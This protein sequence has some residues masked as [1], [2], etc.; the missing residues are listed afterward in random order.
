MFV[1]FGRVV[2]Q[3]K[4]VTNVACTRFRVYDSTR[5]GTFKPYS[6][7]FLKS[8]PVRV[9]MRVESQTPEKA[10]KSFIFLPLKLG[11]VL[12][13]SPERFFG[14]VLVYIT[15]NCATN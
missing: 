9:E 11:A 13:L 12:L 15:K 10:L 5:S 4:E 14:S 6:S 1:E 2:A 8:K 3:S 7:M